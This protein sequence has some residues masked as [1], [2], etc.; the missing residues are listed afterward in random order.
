MNS[1]INRRLVALAFALVGAAMLQA[2]A[3]TTGGF[4]ASR[5]VNSNRSMTSR[6]DVLRQQSAP[7][8]GHRIVST[9]DGGVFDFRYY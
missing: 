3:V 7:S 2:C 6:Y 9:R 4:T 5:S 1:R 8:G